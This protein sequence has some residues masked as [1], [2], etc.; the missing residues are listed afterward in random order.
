MREIIIIEKKIIDKELFEDLFPDRKN[1]IYCIPRDYDEFAKTV[2]AMLNTE[3]GSIFFGV[4]KGVI[5]GI[6]DENWIRYLEILGKRIQKLSKNIKYHVYSL[7]NG[8]YITEVIV[9]KSPVAC[10][11]KDKEWILDGGKVVGEI[12]G[13]GEIGFG[14]KDLRLDYTFFTSPFEVG[15][16]FDG[17][18]GKTLDF[19]E[20]VSAFLDGKVEVGDYAKKIII[21]V[22][23][24]GVIIGREMRVFGEY[25]RKVN[26]IFQYFQNQ[27]GVEFAEKIICNKIPV[28]KYDYY[29]IVIEIPGY[30]EEEIFSEFDIL[31]LGFFSLF[32]ETKCEDF[33]KTLSKTKNLHYLLKYILIFFINHQEFT[34]ILENT[35]ATQFIKKLIDQPL[36]D[37]IVNLLKHPIFSMEYNYYKDIKSKKDFIKQQ[38]LKDKQW[39]YF[40]EKLHYFTPTKIEKYKKEIEVLPIGQE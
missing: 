34:Y 35:I 24:E 6:E 12:F 27:F 28:R 2:C 33:I 9:K 38:T 39:S 40:K 19:Y 37:D 32:K 29:L 18:R 8:R 13:G 26:L 1:I 21:G 16:L 25:E 5:E 20:S 23:G 3:G 4:N 15:K 30:K 10:K 31:K 36:R 7:K 17:E 14:E 11:Y 22:D